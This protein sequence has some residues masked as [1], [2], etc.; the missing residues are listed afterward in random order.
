MDGLKR[1]D[2]EELRRIYKRL[3]EIA[4]E[5]GFIIEGGLNEIIS[6]IAFVEKIAEYKA[7]RYRQM[8]EM[9]CY[10]TNKG[11]GTLR[12]RWYILS[13]EPELVPI[14]KMPCRGNHLKS[15]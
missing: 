8:L 5:K 13:P 14:P 3:L 6:S 7:K 10:L 11:G 9:Q 2:I 12:A 15:D 4:D 1:L